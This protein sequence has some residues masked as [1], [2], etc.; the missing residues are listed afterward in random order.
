MKKIA[1]E[2]HMS[3]TVMILQLAKLYDWLFGPNILLTSTKKVR[4]SAIRESWWRFCR[5][6]T[7]KELTNFQIVKAYAESLDSTPINAWLDVRVLTKWPITRLLIDH[8]AQSWKSPK[9]VTPSGLVAP[10]RQVCITAIGLGIFWL[11]LVD[12]KLTNKAQRHNKPANRDEQRREL[13]RLNRIDQAKERRVHDSG[14]LL[15]VR[16]VHFHAQLFFTYL[17]NFKELPTSWCSRGHLQ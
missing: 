13:A 15:N 16:D 9:Y 11:K 1:Y 5:V 6:Y 8:T 14:G 17:C 10:V 4:I 2:R 12:I 3:G 7:H